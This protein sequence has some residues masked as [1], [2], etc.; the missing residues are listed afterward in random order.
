MRGSRAS[1]ERSARARRCVPGVHDEQWTRSAPIRGRLQAREEYPR[2]GLQSFPHVH[3][4]LSHP[5]SPS[6][7]SSYHLHR[8][9]PPT[10]FTPPIS[11]SI[12]SNVLNPVPHL[13]TLA[14][15]LVPLTVFIRLLAPSESPSSGSFMLSS[16]LPN[17]VDGGDVLAEVSAALISQVGKMKRTGL[18]WEDKASFL[19]FYNR[20]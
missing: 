5:V 2:E 4:V 13:F 14:S 15:T 17:G 12:P 3:K 11:H 1:E 8:H 6:R 16:V 9:D 7:A 10:S 20:K 18:G 19:E